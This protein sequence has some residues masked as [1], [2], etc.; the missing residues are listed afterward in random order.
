M[1]PIVGANNNPGVI[2]SFPS[3]QY[4]NNG[5]IS[6]VRMAMP[7]QFYPSANSSLF[8]SARNA[9]I[10]NV[11]K[12]PDNNQASVAEYT[13]KKKWGNTSSSEV[14]YMR[15]VNAI[16]KSSIQSPAT[17]QQL[18]FR[19]QDTTSRNQALRRC[20]SGGCVAPKKKGANIAFKSGGGSIMSSAGNRQ[21]IA[22]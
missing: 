9:Y 3:K 21:I 18:S 1:N 16:G 7:S 22:P 10:N 5:Y 15:R 8:S 13:K 17:L 19:S 4:T 2:N 12:G 11:G 20:R 6:N 14:T